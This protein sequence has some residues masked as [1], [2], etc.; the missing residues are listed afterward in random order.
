LQSPNSGNYNSVSI[1]LTRKPT[2]DELMKMRSRALSFNHCW[3]CP[4]GISP[5][6]YANRVLSFRLIK[7]VFTEEE[8]DRWAIDWEAQ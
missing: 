1:F 3:K 4:S 5:E 8:L 6:H 2:D 7:V